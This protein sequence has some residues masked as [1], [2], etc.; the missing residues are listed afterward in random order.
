MRKRL[1]EW[2]SR[3]MVFL[4]MLGAPLLADRKRT[5]WGLTGNCWW[6]ATPNEMTQSE[7]LVPEQQPTKREDAMKAKT[8]SELKDDAYENGFEGAMS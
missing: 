1:P 4:E 3:A 7:F 6:S 5:G 2:L 8:P